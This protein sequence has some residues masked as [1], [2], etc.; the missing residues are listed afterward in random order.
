MPPVPPHYGQPAPPPP[1]YGQPAPPPPPYGQSAPPSYTPP[2]YGHPT[3][4]PYAHPVAPQP[5]PQPQ[6]VPPPYPQQPTEGPEFMA[7][8][9]HNSIVV[10]SAGVAFE[11]HGHSAEFPWHEIRSV[12]YKAGPNGKTLMMAVIHLDGR[13]YECVVDAKGRDPLGAW[14]AQLAPVLGYYKPLV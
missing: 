8:D 13:V 11:D 5:Y 14:F 7:V 12:H 2:P 3:P 4:P 1:Q 9:R 10:D 6:P